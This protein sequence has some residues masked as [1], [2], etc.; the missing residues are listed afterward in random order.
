MLIAYMV[1]SPHVGCVYQVENI[2]LW[3]EWNEEIIQTNRYRISCVIF[4][5]LIPFIYIHHIYYMLH[6]ICIAYNTFI[7]ILV[8]LGIVYHQK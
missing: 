3:Y 7:K 8:T 6:G 2:E 1:K 5:L 4:H